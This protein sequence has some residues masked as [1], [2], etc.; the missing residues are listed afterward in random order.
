MNDRE[1]EEYLRGLLEKDT[2]ESGKKVVVAGIS[3]NDLIPVKFIRHC[4]LANRMVAIMHHK[5]EYADYFDGVLKCIF[6]TWED[7]TP[8]D[9]IRWLK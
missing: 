6:K 8:E 1:L 9:K 2:E 7:S 3:M 5:K 4:T